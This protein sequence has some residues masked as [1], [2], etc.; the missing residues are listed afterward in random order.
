M[1]MAT[2]SPNNQLISRQIIIFDISNS[3][4]LKLFLMFQLRSGHTL[5]YS[6]YQKNPAIIEKIEWSK[7]S[8]I[9][10]VRKYTKR[11]L[12]VHFIISME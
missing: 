8:Y 3:P 7:I 1:F 12:G 4:I 6:L 5:S 2:I 9:N 11:P 10:F